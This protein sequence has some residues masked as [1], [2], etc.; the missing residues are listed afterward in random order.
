MDL[1]E[2]IAP[3]SDQ[4]DAVDLITGSRIFTIERVSNGPADQPVNIHLAEFPRP[5]RPGLSMRR[6]LVSLWGKDGD[7]YVGRRVELFCDATVEFA[8]QAVGGIRISRMSHIDCPKKVPLIVSRGKSATFPVKP[9]PDAAPPPRRT[10]QPLPDRIEAAVAAYARANVTVPML[11]A[12][13]AR[14]R[15]E[16]DDA[17][18]AALEALF[19]SL[20]AGETTKA[21]EFDI[22]TGDDA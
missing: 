1:S 18:V 9:L 16:W 12:R 6:V 13:I 7:V 3:N 5:W 14:P 21:A 8:G 11:E 4:L 17:N 22:P 10:E 19:R 2:T 20:S 15:D